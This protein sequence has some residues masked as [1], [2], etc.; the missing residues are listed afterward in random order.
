MKITIIILLILLGISV[1]VIYNLLRKTEKFEESILTLEANEIMY[2]KHL[3][4]L[5]N[6]IEDSNV[7]IKQMDSRGIMES[8]DEVGFFIK[9]IKN[10]QKQLNNFKTD[11]NGTN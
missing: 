2:Q 7:K 3:D 4:I 6:F 5:N 9:N 10:I 8:D 1:Y 11:R